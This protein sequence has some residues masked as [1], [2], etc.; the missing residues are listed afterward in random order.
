MPRAAL[1]RG[2]GTAVLVC[3]FVLIT[4]CGETEDASLCDAYQQYVVTLDRVLA[5]DPTGAT[6]DAAADAV[7]SVLDSVS[8]LSAAA[9]SRFT[10]EL[11]SLETSLDD[12]R[13]TLESVE[14]S[15]DYATWEPLVG[16]SLEDVVDEAFAITELIEP[17]CNPGS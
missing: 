13:A 9:D 16:D 2:A 3:G 8:Q 7:E 5:A 10:A 17:Q 1:R 4:A 6:A 11:S 14:D 15:A 12:L